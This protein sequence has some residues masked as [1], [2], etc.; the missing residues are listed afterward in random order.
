MRNEPNRTGVAK[1]SCLVLYQGE[2]TKQCIPSGEEKSAK[3]IEAKFN[4][5]KKN[6][7]LS[8]LYT[9]R[10]GWNTL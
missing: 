10:G 4:L 8:V 2:K 9:V 1:K 6:L 5:T 7:K 3:S